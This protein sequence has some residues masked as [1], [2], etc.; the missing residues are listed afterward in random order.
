MI[1]KY[2]DC[3]VSN[4]IGIFI[5]SVGFC[6]YATSYQH[7]HPTY[8]FVISPTKESEVIVREIEVPKE[9]VF[10]IGLAPNIPHEEKKEDMFK[11]YIAVM[12]SNDLFEKEMGSN[13]ELFYQSNDWVQFI[14]P[15]EIL[16]YIKLFT[17]EYENDFST[18]NKFLD[19]LGVIITRLIARNM[20]DVNYKDMR[21]EKLI[22][23]KAE[24]NQV[25]EYILQNFGKKLNNKE[26]SR[27]ANLSET[28]FIGLFKS[29]IGVTPMEYVHNIRLEKAKK[30]LKS[31]DKSITEI[32]LFCGFSSTSHFSNNFKKSYNLTPREYQKIYA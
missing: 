9:H 31:Q 30:L 13:I 20:L 2:I 25:L 24:L 11:R 15:S 23:I 18:E 1:L 10:T 26:L 6:G 16:D 5:P 28:Y 12:I 19:E 22:N 32:A 8:S 29:Q 14:L 17:T 3:Y 21:D 4:N 7:I 27:I